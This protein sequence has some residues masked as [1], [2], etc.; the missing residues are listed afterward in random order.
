MG[1]AVDGSIPREETILI[2]DDEIEMAKCFCAILENA[3]YGTIIAESGEEAVRMVS[4]RKFDAVIM[5]LVM[6]GMDGV[7]AV[8]EIKKLVAYDE[9]LPVILITAFFSEDNKIAG[10]SFADGFMSKPVSSNELIATVRSLLKIR[11]LTRELALAK[12]KYHRFYDNIPHL[13]ISVKTDGTIISSNKLFCSFCNAPKSKIEGTSVYAYLR[14][15]EHSL[16]A[17]FIEAVTT[18]VGILHQNI[19]T[20]I[21][22]ATG[23]PFNLSVRAALCLPW[24]T[25]RRGSALRKKKKSRASNCIEALT[26]LL[27][28]PCRRVSR[29]K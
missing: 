6:R 18:T 23:K 11:R 13:C 21:L 12:E 1:S 14:P 28:A 10:L 22:P 3:G 29:M 27:S 4:E 17:A 20:F 2:V 19:F 24:R 8:K 16:F 25:S 7:T 5:D 9:F 15:E 26:S